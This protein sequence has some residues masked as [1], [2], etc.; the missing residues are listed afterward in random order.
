[1]VVLVALH[2]KVGVFG[3]TVD[4]G[5]FRRVFVA[6]F[7]CGCFGLLLLEGVDCVLDEIDG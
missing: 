7:A 2:A 3:D 6:V 5:R 4:L 1:M